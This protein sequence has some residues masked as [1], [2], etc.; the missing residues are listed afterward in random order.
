MENEINSDTGESYLQ[1]I[2]VKLFG[3]GEVMKLI[4]EVSDTHPLENR[5]N[6]E[7][8]HINWEFCSKVL[9]NGEKRRVLKK[10]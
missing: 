4:D 10:G 7:I 1:K 9:D 6:K 3:K 2:D 8:K 5:Y